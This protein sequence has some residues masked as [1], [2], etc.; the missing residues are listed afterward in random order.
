MGGRL[1]GLSALAMLVALPLVG[2]E[3]FINCSFSPKEKHIHD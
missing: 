1:P 3:L 2:S